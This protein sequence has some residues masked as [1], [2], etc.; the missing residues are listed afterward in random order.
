MISCLPLINSDRLRQRLSTVYPRA[1]CSGLREFQLFSAPR[2]F[3]IAVSLVKGGARFGMVFG[4]AFMTNSLGI[5]Y[6]DD[7]AYTWLQFL[8]A[9]LIAV[10]FICTPVSR[11]EAGQSSIVS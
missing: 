10:L 9:A 11:E 4:R 6:F 8:V 1:T 5:T 3:R 7:C 2:T